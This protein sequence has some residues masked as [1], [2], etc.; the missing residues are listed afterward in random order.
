VSDRT[1]DGARA[2]HGETAAQAAERLR[3]G[4]SFGAAASAYAAPR[5]HDPAAADRGALP[6]AAGR[7]PTRVADVGA[8]TGKL[9]AALVRLGAEVTA[10]EPDPAMLAE[11]RRAMPAAR[12]VPGSA[13]A[14]PLPDASVDAVLAGQAM[15][16]FDLDLALPEIARVLVPGGVFAGLWNVHDDRVGWVAGLAEIS[17]SQASATLTRWRGG[18]GRCREE[19]LAEAGRGLF[20]SPE[21]AEFGHGQPRTAGSLLAAIATHSHLLVMQEAERARLL[22]QIEGFLRSRPET[23]AGPFT[24][25]L[26]TVALRVLRS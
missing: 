17:R 1:A 22:A 23:S 15:H 24:L 16:W 20:G 7:R 2:G 13:E 9:T 12:S 8:G 3:R 25:P 6:P 14:L 18:T 4:S 10:V 19:R 21:Q 5:P 11:L 26:V